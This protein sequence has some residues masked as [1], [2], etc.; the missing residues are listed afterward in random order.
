MLSR[1]FGVLSK[2]TFDSDS[3]QELQ[4]IYDRLR[5]KK[6][7]IGGPRK[8]K[9]RSPKDQFTLYATNIRAALI[10]AFFNETGKFPAGVRPRT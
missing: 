2:H 4:K 10:A 9:S 6:L 8:I 3:K 1:L 7:I 5:H